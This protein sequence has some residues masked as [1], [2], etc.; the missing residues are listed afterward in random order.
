MRER[1]QC[2]GQAEAEYMGQT[3]RCVDVLVGECERHPL[4]VSVFLITVEK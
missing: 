2:T 4:I 1:I 3:G